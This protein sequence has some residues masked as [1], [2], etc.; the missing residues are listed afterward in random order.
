MS[1]RVGEPDHVENEDPKDACEYM[2]TGVT[3]AIALAE[4]LT[5]VGCGGGDDDGSHSNQRSTDINGNNNTLPNNR[6]ND[7]NGNNASSNSHTTSATTTT[8]ATMS[9]EQYLSTLQ[10]TIARHQSKK[11]KPLLP[12]G[13]AR[14]LQVPRPAILLFDWTILLFD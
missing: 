10:T 9:R 8:T 11:V 12:Y 1:S 3:L 2:S 7:N 4:R 5:L 14:A 13:A 6:V